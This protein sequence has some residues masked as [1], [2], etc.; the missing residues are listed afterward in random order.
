[1]GLFDFL[2]K[3]I[4]S[5]NPPPT[6]QKEMKSELTYADKERILV[7][8][9]T[10]A[11]VRQF[12]TMPY[13]LN[14]P[15]HKYNEPG[16]HAF[17]YMDLTPKNIRIAKVELEKLNVIIDY[18]REKIPLIPKWARINVD[19]IAF[20]NYSEDYGYTRLMCLPYTYSGKIERFP[21]KLF[22]VSFL[23][24]DS[25]GIQVNGDIKYS[26]DGRIA[27]ATVNC[28]NRSSWESPANGWQYIFYDNDGDLTMREILS[29]IRPD[30]YGRPTSIYKCPELLEEERQ[31]EQDKKTLQWLQKNI[32]S[33]APK[34]LSGFRRM[35]ST[36]S[37]NY[38]R[39][40]EEAA[41]L[42]KNL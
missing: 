13:D 19:R 42:G 17:A 14:C 12:T 3:K 7:E 32:P 8:R 38:Q 2:K 6:T 31:R 4:T 24:A 30:E 34:S 26:V 33:I 28:W 21:L 29:T 10:E 9:M 1:M 35:R 22:F 11:D 39:I 5:V 36:N 15:L 27:H 37:K 23:S 16:T 40:V 25:I 20:H 41:K 18:A